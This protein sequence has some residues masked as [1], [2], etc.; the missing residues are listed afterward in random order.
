MKKIRIA[1]RVRR[2]NTVENV[3]DVLRKLYKSKRLV[4]KSFK[5]SYIETGLEEKLRMYESYVGESMGIDS[6]IK[7]LTDEDYYKF[8][9]DLNVD[10]EV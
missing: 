5:E 4:A 9:R 10:L 1:V 8:I 7:I 3:V 6:A 2:E